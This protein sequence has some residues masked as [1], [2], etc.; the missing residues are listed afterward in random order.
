MTFRTEKA[1]QELTPEKLTYLVDMYKLAKTEKERAEVETLFKPYV[2][3]KVAFREFLH[4]KLPAG[5]KAIAM[6]ATLL[7]LGDVAAPLWERIDGPDRMGL[8]TALE[9]ARS[10]RDEKTEKVT[11]HSVQAVLKEYDT[12]PSR[13][14]QDGRS[15]KYRPLN[16]VLP[17]K[18]REGQRK[19]EKKGKKNEDNDTHFWRN[20]RES[21]ISFIGKKMEG[22]DPTIAHQ[23]AKRME[24]DLKTMVEEWQSKLHSARIHGFTNSVDTSVRRSAVLDAC[25][26]LSLDPPKVGQE[27]NLKKARINKLRLARE[28]H[29]DVNTQHDTRENYQAVIGAYKILEQYNE[30]FAV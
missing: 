30:Q 7:A 13:K 22:L 3:Y 6:R 9:L 1:V 5:K 4:D 24:S 2:P 15:I 21:L 29:P 8:N 20:L 11:L 10:A 19:G 27:A 17:M 16:K 26:T 23:Q 28:Y 25:R 12:W 14:D 18:W